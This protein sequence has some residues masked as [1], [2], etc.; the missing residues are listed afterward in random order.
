ML[1][2]LPFAYK[3]TS[4]PALACMA[5]ALI[6]LTAWINT[7]GSKRTL[8]EIETGYYS[9]VE[10]GHQLFMDL[11][12]IHRVFQD[13]ATIADIDTLDEGVALRDGFLASLDAGR[14]NTVVDTT[15]FDDIGAQFSIY[16]E[17]AD[18]TTRNLINGQGGDE[19]FEKLG[20][21]AAKYA[22]L[23]EDIV[24]MTEADKQSVSEAF[25]FARSNHDRSNQ[26]MFAVAAVSAILLVL[27]ST[28]IVR[29]TLGAMRAGVRGMSALANGD[30]SRQVEHRSE[31]EIGQMVAS[32]GE[33]T[34]TIHELANEV[35]TLIEAVR[36]GRL[37]VRGDPARFQ[38][39]YG[40]LVCNFNELVDAFVSPIEMT[41]NFVERISKGDIPP[42]MTEHYEGDFSR[43]K[44]N[45]NA[46]VR[47]LNGLVEQ[48]ADVTAAARSGRLSQRGD[49]SLFSGVWGD[50]IRGVNDTVEAVALPIDEVS[51]VMSNLAKGDLTTTI[52]S[53]YEGDFAK[54]RDDVNVTVAK[55]TDVIRSIKT[56][57]E[58]VSSAADEMA[59]G[60]Q[61]LRQRTDAHVSNLKETAS[62]MNAMTETVQQN[63]NNAREA[64]DL[65]VQARDKAKQ[66]GEVVNTVVTAMDEINEASARIAD[67]I[68]VIDEIAFQTNLLALNAA[69]EAARAGEQGRGFAVV[70]SEVRVLAGRTATAAKEIAGLIRDSSDKVAQ[71]SKLVDESGQ[72]LNEIIAAVSNVT[73]VVSA[74]ADASN[75]QSESISEVD[76]AIGRMESMTQENA[77][78]VERATD[79]SLS[80][81]D[82]A[83]KLKDLMD[84]FSVSA[85]D[86]AA[87][88]EEPR[89]AAS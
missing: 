67:I 85:T 46:L 66:G 64:N 25:A 20:L 13:A 10:L 14:S 28:L 62:S 56:S 42:E 53:H 40:E 19:I 29:A 24:A 8:N 61:T 54:L 12:V 21:V 43:T 51:H 69:V 27:T 26:L 88:Q 68:D 4:L 37:D 78:L 72:T 65:A 2:N 38:G 74:I 77:S 15:R 63:A 84:F 31:D 1:R 60:N 57:S 6:L 52:S 71:G 17:F 81:G 79:S 36:A 18:S 34:G 73:D 32:V 39:A 9:S 86:T 49:A 80:M 87:E 33:V 23:Q 3:I 16:Y 55:L 35:S 5:M 70:A 11:G 50:L 30:L 41:A 7:Q 44:E 47:T 83:R 22:A 89:R 59:V 75:N 76:S 48:L 82:D 58:F 45:L